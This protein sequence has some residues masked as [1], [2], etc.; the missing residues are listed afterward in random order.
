MIL[1][2]DEVG[3]GS[4]A[5]PLV[6]GAVVLGGVAIEG[7]TDSKKLSKKRREE[8][9][10]IIRDKAAGIGI[11]WVS[12]GEIDEIG[13]S[14]A[15]KLATI[16]AVE[17]V[18]CAYDEIIIDGTV[19][20]LAETGKGKYVKTMPKADL[21]IP[22]VS[23]ASIIAKVARDNYMAKQSLE[24]RGYG[25]EKHVG[26]GTK[27]HSDALD[28]IGI[29]P[30]H[31]LSFKPMEKYLNSSKNIGNQAED[32]AAKYLIKKGH[33]IIA[34]NWKTKRCEIDIV[35]RLHDKLFFVEVKYRSSRD[36]GGG[37]SAITSQ[38]LRRMRFGAEI[39]LAHNNLRDIDAEL[40]VISVSGQPMIIEQFLEIL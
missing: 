3:R 26:Y 21:L 1:G 31:R 2:I 14:R 6:V 34:K 40:A 12:P 29:T 38:K 27:V 5:G 20:F 7:L 19:N 10:L 15:L 28:K 17:Q 13:L 24:Y 25:F 18:K 32:F 8:L 35:S 30:M 9:D 36:Q 4:W 23:A 11:G 37:T 33:K 39:Y 16:R 22:S